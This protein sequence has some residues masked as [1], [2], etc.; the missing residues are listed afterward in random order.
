MFFFQS[1]ECEESIYNHVRL[2]ES[3]K[4]VEP[5]WMLLRSQTGGV[6]D[7][8]MG[9][10]L[11]FWSN[12]HGSNPGSSWV[13]EKTQE[14]STSIQLR[15][16]Q[17]GSEE[18][19]KELDKM[20]GETEIDWHLIRESVAIPIINLVPRRTILTAQCLGRER[21]NAVRWRHR[22]R[23]SSDSVEPKMLRD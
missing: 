15:V 6:G 4:S 17:Y 5:Y 9:S 12:D 11:D 14:Q 20:L 21:A 10:V 18:L 23:L 3:G 8:I 7:G 16:Y 19:W 22:S 2:G 13:L 1:T